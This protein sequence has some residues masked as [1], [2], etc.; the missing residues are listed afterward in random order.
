MIFWDGGV[1]FGGFMFLT[2]LVIG[3]IRESDKF[4]PLWPP[5]FPVYLHWGL[6]LTINP[7]ISFA[8]GCLF[9]FLMWMLK[10][11]FEAHRIK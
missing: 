5:T 3:L 9:G 4:F 1:K 10:K 7:V 11:S 6:N 2:N 8:S